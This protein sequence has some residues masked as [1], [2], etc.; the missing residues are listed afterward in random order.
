MK[1][2]LKPAPHTQEDMAVQVDVVRR[3]GRIVDGSMLGYWVMERGIQADRCDAR[4]MLSL[5]SHKAN[6]APAHLVR[7]GQLCGFDPYLGAFVRVPE[8]DAEGN[9]TNFA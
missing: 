2:R 4:L 6:G 7:A 8:L 1:P 3:L 5:E 9:I